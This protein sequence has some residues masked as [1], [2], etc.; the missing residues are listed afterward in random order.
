VGGGRD[1]LG[2][3]DR[4][5]VAG[6][7]LARDEAGEVRAVELTGHPF[8]LATLYQPERS[9]L[10]GEG[11]PLVSAF[12]AAVSTSPRGPGEPAA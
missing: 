3:R 12:V 5:E 1:D 6:Q 4:V 8:F 2:V 7:D 10:R 9:A 11:H